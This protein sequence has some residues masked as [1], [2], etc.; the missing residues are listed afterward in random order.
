VKNCE[1]HGAQAVLLYWEPHDAKDDIDAPVDAS[2]IPFVSSVTYSTES[3]IWRPSIPCQ[4]ISSNQAKLVLSLLYQANNSRAAPDSWQGS[5]VTSYFLGGQNS[6]SLMVHLSVFNKPEKQR[7]Q[8][9]VST[10]QGTDEPDRYVIVG[11]PRSSL[12][13][14]SQD[15][16]A[17]TS[18]LIQLAH[19]FHYMYNQH[20]WKPRRGVKLISWGG[21][22]FSNS[23]MLHYINNYHLLLN[24]RAV[25]YFDLSQLAVGNGSIVANIPPGIHQLV[26][27]TTF[28][29]PDPRNAEQTLQMSWNQLVEKDK[30]L[31]Q[32]D[33]IPLE[34]Y[35]SDST[36][37]PFLHVVGIPEVKLQYRA[38]PGSQNSVQAM[39]SEDLGHHYKFHMTVT[40][41]VTKTLLTI[42]DNELLPLNLLNEASAIQAAM[43]QT[44]DVLDHC[45]P[46]MDHFNPVTTLSEDL[47]KT[48]EDFREVASMF[49]KRFDKPGVRMVNDI[50]MSFQQ[51]FLKNNNGLSQHILYPALADGTLMKALDL[52]EVLEVTQERNITT[53]LAESL[54]RALKDAMTLLHFSA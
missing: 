16:V 20:Q 35:H 11:A 19:S 6:D 52:C 9:F 7:I 42:I 18:V 26:T 32:Q 24:R 29:V 38:P 33:I 48:A 51:F 28:D 8:N 41:I 49:V 43:W 39:T 46:D 10:V 27:A 13:G 54:T 30:H 50:S 40:H 5:L 3:T 14:Q 36:H 15:A 2:Y 34:S 44:L 47:L 21:A 22:E 12:P 23:G 25:A 1:A 31:N 4:T 53:E 45:Y 37:N 17:S